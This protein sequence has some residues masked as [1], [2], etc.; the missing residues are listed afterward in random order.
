MTYEEVKEMVEAGEL[1]LGEG[2]LIGVDSNAGSIMS[3]LRNKLK[4]AGWNH[5]Q[6][7]AVAL[8]VF[9]NCNYQE[10]IC[11]AD[12]LLEDTSEY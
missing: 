10:L 12:S 7:Q 8:H 3:Y 1:Q 5:E 9:T 11:V 4:R 2:T 6:C